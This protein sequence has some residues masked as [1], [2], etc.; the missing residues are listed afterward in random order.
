MLKVENLSFSYGREGI[1][2]DICFSAEPGKIT[3]LIGT[4]GAGDY[5]KIRLS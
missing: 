4:N 3:V 2:K 1:L 5:V